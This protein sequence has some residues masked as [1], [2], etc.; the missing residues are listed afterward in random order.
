[1]QDARESYLAQIEVVA[2]AYLMDL[3]RGPYDLFARFEEDFG[4][5]GYAAPPFNVDEQ[6]ALEASPNLTA[7]LKDA[8]EV[9]GEDEGATPDTLSRTRA[10]FVIR[11]DL[12]SRIEELQSVESDRD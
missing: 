4:P 1:M 3:E 2:R 11:L 9:L 5:G 12:M 6:L 8:E 7:G 10:Y